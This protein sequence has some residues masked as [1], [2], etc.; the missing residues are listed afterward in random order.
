MAY[1]IAISK[2][3]ETEKS[4]INSDIV[5]C[6]TVYSVLDA[7]NKARADRDEN[8]WRYTNKNGQVVILRDRF[9][10]IVEGFTK[11]AGFVSTTVQTPQPEVTSLVWAAARSLIEVISFFCSNSQRMC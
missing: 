9:D 2:L 1:D 5:S 11:Y 10:K 7:A 8:K 6:Y 3:N 4:Q